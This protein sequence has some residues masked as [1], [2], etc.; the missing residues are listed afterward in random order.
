MEYNIRD[1]RAGENSNNW[2]LGVTYR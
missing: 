1:E 2:R